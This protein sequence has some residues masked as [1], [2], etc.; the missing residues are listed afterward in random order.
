MIL[1]AMGRE[2]L[3]FR[4]NACRIDVKVAG[5]ASQASGFVYRTKP[6][7]D[8]DYVLTV[9]HAFQEGNEMPKVKKL[10]NLNI[11]YG[12]GRTER[13]ERYDRKN[14]CTCLLFLDDLDMTIIRVKKQNLPN[15]RRIAVKNAVDTD[16]DYLMNA[17]SFINIHR[18]EST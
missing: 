16:V 5:S 17:H 1:N 3:N 15:V 10:S 4:H 9:K 18:E 13:I 8:Y 14:L 12:S 7:C 11:S 2:H 6:S